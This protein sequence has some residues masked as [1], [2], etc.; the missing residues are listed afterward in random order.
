MRRQEVE[1]KNF[2]QEI[3]KWKWTWIDD[4]W[5][6]PKYFTIDPNTFN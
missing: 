6:I 1:F 2:M 4:Y 3:A 5:L